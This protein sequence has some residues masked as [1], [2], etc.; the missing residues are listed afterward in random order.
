MVLTDGCHLKSSFVVGDGIVIDSGKSNLQL[1]GSILTLMC[2]YYTFDLEYPRVYSQLLGAL[3]VV[4]FGDPYD[5]LKSR[6]WKEF[7]EC[8]RPKM[9]EDC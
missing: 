9:A 2:S 5:H 1:A 6:N 3:Q 7:I 4:L 8:L